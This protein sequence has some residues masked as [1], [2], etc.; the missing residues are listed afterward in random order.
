LEV[1]QGV[2]QIEI[3]LANTD[4][5]AVNCYLIEGDDNRH[6]LIDTGW[7][8]P[9]AFT[10]LLEGLR[11]YRMGFNNIG[12][13]LITHVH[14]DHFGQAGKVKQLSN[15]EIS[16]HQVE[17]ALIESRYVNFD[18]LMQQMN[19]L[20]QKNGVP[21]S[22]T[23]DMA[24][25]ATPIRPYVIPTNP[26]R[27]LK[28]GETFKVGSFELEVINTPGHSPGHVCFYEKTKKLL[29]SG[30]HVL[31]EITP[32]VS[33]H[34]QSGPNPLKDFI[35]SLERLAELEVNFVFPGHGPVFSGLRQRIG[36]IIYHHEQRQLYI[37]SAARDE[38]KTAWEI[39]NALQWGSNHNVP[40]SKLAMLHQRLAVMETIA[41]LQFLVAEDKAKR[42]VEG[43]TVKYYTGG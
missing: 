41:H 16:I 17:A 32:N 27:A 34:P 21:S 18:I 14:A 28:G 2:H 4:L 3:P 7:D 26:D 31:L 5:K 1:V 13:I 29:F 40:F 23:P 42:V 22:T 6:A 20:L 19:L 8:R 9:E 35:D 37:K 30:D 43:E 15:A 10:A 25:V 33:F 38:L 11:Q 39:A 24:R 36:Q 12:Q